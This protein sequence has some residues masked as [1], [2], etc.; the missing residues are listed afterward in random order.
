MQE[1]WREEISMMMDSREQSIFV[2]RRKRGK[3]LWGVRFRKVLGPNLA[4]RLGYWD[5]NLGYPQIKVHH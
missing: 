4:T 1:I 5:L 3:G 2:L